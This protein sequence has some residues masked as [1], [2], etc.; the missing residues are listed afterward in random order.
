MASVKVEAA[1]GNTMFDT[2]PSWTDITSY[3]RAVDTDRGRPSVDGR[4]TTGRASVVLDNRDGRFNP[5]NT[6]GA[7]YPNVTIGVPMRVTVVEGTSSSYPVFYG[8]A[9]EWSPDYPKSQDSTV[10]VPLADGFYNLNLEDLAAESFTA[11][12]TDGRITDVLDAVGWPPALRDLDTGIGTVQATDFAQPNDGGEQPALNHLCD[13]AEAEAGVLFM[14]ADGKVVFQN[15]V[16]MSGATPAATF[17]DAEMSG[18]TVAYTDDYLWNVIRVAREDGLQVEYDASGTGP[19]RVLTRDVMPMGNDAEVLNVAQWLAGMFGE[20]RER[21][22]SLTLKPLAVGVDTV[23][24]LELRN[25]V[26]VQHT[27]PGGDALDQDCAVEQISHSFRKGDWTTVLSVAPLSTV[28]SQA[29]WI[30]GTS[31]LGVST[32]LA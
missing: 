5:G 2:S 12:T 23:F 6:A 25:M 11:D 16:A 7:Y 22:T 10:T 13:V 31:E 15:R 9:R 17:T 26:T 8:S 29:Y 19:R 27:P 28:E 18:L 30:L 3:V 14:G 24:G 21:I 20:Q 32:R 4:F 1:F